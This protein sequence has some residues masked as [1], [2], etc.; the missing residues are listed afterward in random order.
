MGKYRILDENLWGLKGW[1]DA[2]IFNQVH[3][4]GNNAPDVCIREILNFGHWLIA[5]ANQQLEACL[6]NCVN[7]SKTCI[8]KS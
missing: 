8:Y 6:C 5:H 2:H 7:T 4:L 3:G 1:K